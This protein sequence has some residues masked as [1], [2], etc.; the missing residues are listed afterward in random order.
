MG[1]EALALRLLHPHDRKVPI[2]LNLLT[3]AHDP[4]DHMDLVA[5]DRQ[6]G[7]QR[8]EAEIRFSKGFE[9]QPT[10]LLGPSIRS[11]LPTRSSIVS[12]MN[13]EMV[14]YPAAFAA[15]SRSTVFGTRTPYSFRSPLE[16]LGMSSPFP[17]W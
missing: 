16:G 5:T 13:C 3:Y 10:G 2:T 6:E 9:S 12:A 1:L 8:S 11:S 15:S 17:I 7:R 4:G 14:S